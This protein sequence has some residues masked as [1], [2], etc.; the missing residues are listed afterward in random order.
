M[1]R[2]TLRRLLQLIPVLFGITIMTFAILRSIPGDPVAIMAPTDATQEDID[3]IRAEYGLD[4]P[5]P[6]QYLTY[7]ANV[8]RG[9]LGV[10][11]RTRDSVAETLVRRLQ[12]TV[13]LTLVSIWLGV[14]M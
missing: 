2:Y 6:I 1:L 4:Q 8:L 7:V 11:I 13:E 12:F 3:R 9:D 5:L 10:S 14:L